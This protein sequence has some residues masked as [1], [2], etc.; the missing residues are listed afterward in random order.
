MAQCLVFKLVLASSGVKSP[1]VWDVLDSEQGRNPGLTLYTAS[2]LVALPF[3]T[4]S[5]S[6]FS[7]LMHVGPEEDRRLIHGLETAQGSGQREIPLEQL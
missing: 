2:S 7:S 5:G 4:L 3:Q 1:V 6:A